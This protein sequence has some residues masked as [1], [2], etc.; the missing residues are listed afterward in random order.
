MGRIT[1]V[2]AVA[3]TLAGLAL[4]ATGSAWA[5]FPGKD[6]RLSFAF[7]TPTSGLQI[8]TMRPDGSGL[9]VL[10]KNTNGSASFES[11]WSADARWIASD[12]FGAGDNGGSIWRVRS[13]GP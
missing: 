13:D 11:A 8:A 12:R 9:R 2:W 4:A 3:L 5:A 6:G 10:V 7:T 1:R